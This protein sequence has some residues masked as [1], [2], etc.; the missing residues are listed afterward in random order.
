MISGPKYFN[1]NSRIPETDSRD[2]ESETGSLE[3]EKRVHRI[4][5]TLETGLQRMFCSL[6][7]PARVAGGLRVKDFEIWLE[8][9]RC[10]LFKN[11]LKRSRPAPKGIT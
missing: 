9:L 8:I 3:T 1:N 4:Q 10:I 2:P 7:A 6:V 5:D 11:V